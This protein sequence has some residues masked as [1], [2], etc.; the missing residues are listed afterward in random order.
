MDRSRMTRWGW[1]AFAAA[2]VAVGL[3][4]ACGTAPQSGARYQC[5]MHPTMLFDKPGDCPICG[6]RL[7]KV[8]QRTAPTTV[9]RFACPMHPA[10]TS[11][12]PGRCPECGMRLVAVGSRGDFPREHMTYA[13][14]V[15]PEFV[16]DDPDDR[17][18]KCGRKVVE[19]GL[20]A[21]ARP[22]AGAA[23]SVA[24]G[25]GQ[26]PGPAA[27][28]TPRTVLFYR[29]P[30]DPSVTSPVPT[31]DAMGMDYLPVYAGEAAPPAS[32]GV[33][34]LAP[35]QL[36]AEGIRLAGVQTAAAV[37]GR[38]ARAIRTVG[39]VTADET[40]IQHFHTRV[41]GWAEK[42]YVNFT[43]QFVEQG[44]PVISIYSPELV[45][46]QEEFLRA[47]D[48]AARFAASDLPEVRKG[49]E[50]LLAAARRRLR[51]FDVPEEFIAELER[52]GTPQR[53]VTLVAHS[54]GYVTSKGIFHGQQVDPSMMDLFTITDLS[55]VWIDAEFY[56]YEASML[57][58]GQQATLSLAYDPGLRLTGRIAYVYPTLDPATRTIRVRFDFAN[59]EMKLK[60]GMFANVELETEGAR[61]V[62]VPESA[63][64]D[65]GERQVVFVSL[66]G[67]RF[68]PREVALGVRSEGRALVLSGVAAGEQVVVKANF[69]LDSESQLRAL[70]AGASKPTPI[71][72]QPGGG[73]R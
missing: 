21:P 67:G 15:H 49:G 51:L 71:A 25:G 56:E 26:S 30:M 36:T 58:L 41:T 9:P 35:V 14:P 20:S 65:T 13:C 32:A 37:E 5:P 22:S 18:P 7:V 62:T 54:S 8:E 70:I 44:Q 1:V 24:I 17:C 59:P 69:L 11:D 45:A 50:E 61:G 40:R 63:V 2:A 46:S 33:P 16:T 53:E 43:G 47:R 23:T 52:S 3:A 68:E 57:K 39:T 73:R 66:G 19:R 34:G 6:M 64:I 42:L 60:P 28:A 12:Q 48:A 29:N 4:L 72:P 10:E 55:H 27:A 38:L 31:K